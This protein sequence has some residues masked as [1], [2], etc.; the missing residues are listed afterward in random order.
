MKGNFAC[1]SCN[2]AFYMKQLKVS[3]LA[4]GDWVENSTFQ[5]V[6][7][8]LIINL[9]QLKDISGQGIKWQMIKSYAKSQ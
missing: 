4:K 5:L 3:G 2:T 9:K 8:A 1:K 7:A 6:Q